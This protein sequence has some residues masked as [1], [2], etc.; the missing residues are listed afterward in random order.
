MQVY[1]KGGDNKPYELNTYS[2]KV[3]KRHVKEEKEIT[4]KEVSDIYAKLH[5][6]NATD[7]PDRHYLADRARAMAMAHAQQQ[8]KKH[9]GR[10]FDPVTGSLLRKEESEQIDEREL[11]SGETAEKERIVKGMKKGLA[12]FKSRYGSRAKEVMY[13]TATKKA[14]E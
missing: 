6:A 3:P 9:H 4:D 12:G 7:H 1:N 13:A 8:S 2:S 11:S 10:G 14:K 5:H